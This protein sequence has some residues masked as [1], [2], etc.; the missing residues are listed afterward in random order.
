MLV[1]KSKE[2]TDNRNDLLSILISS[3]DK[4]VTGD[5]A[6]KYHRPGNSLYEESK[7]ISD[8]IKNE[9]TDEKFTALK[10]ILN[11]KYAKYA[12]KDRINDIKPQEFVSNFFGYKAY[13]SN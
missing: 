4:M 12:Y 9:L 11:I 5:E 3:L 2:S 10:A 1:K 6:N 13:Q 7:R 8:Y